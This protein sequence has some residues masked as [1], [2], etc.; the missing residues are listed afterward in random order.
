MGTTRPII[1]SPATCRVCFHHGA[2]P[3]PTHYISLYTSFAHSTCTILGK[4]TARRRKQNCSFCRCSCTMRRFVEVVYLLFAN[5]NLHISNIYIYDNGCHICT[6]HPPSKCH[7]ARSSFCWLVVRLAF[8]QSL[9]TETCAS[10]CSFK[11]AISILC[12]K[13]TQGWVGGK[14]R[15]SRGIGGDI[16][17]L[18]PKQ[19]RGHPHVSQYLWYF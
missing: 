5:L 11:L 18:P 8:C 15:H 9:A 3:M 17:T 10:T 6:A 19:M 13:L 14:N 4:T 1:R 12:V 2:Q 7:E 16:P